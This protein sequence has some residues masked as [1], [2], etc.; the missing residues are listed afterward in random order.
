MT[1]STTIRVMISSRGS[2]DISYNGKAAK[3]SQVRL[4]VK[5]D[6]EALKLWAT[7]RQLFEC[8]INEDSSGAPMDQTWWEHCLR[9]AR[10]ADIVIVLYNGESG[11]GI[12][13]EPMGICHSELEAAMARQSAKVR[14]IL[15]PIAGLP[16]DP[17]QRKQDE[18]F[19]KYIESLDIFRAAPAKMGEEVIER[20]RQEVQHAL[21][22]MVQKCALTPDLAKSNTGPALIWHRMSFEERANAMRQEVAAILLD[23]GSS[24]HLDPKR[25]DI[26]SVLLN[27]KRLLVQLHAVPGAFSQPAARERVG[28]PFLLD[29]GLNSLLATCNGGPVH[30]VAGYKTFTESHALKMLGFPDAVVIPGVFG[31]HVADPVQKI[32]F[33]LLKN[34]ESPTSTRRSVIE[35]LEWL[36]RSGEAN[37]L[38]NNAAARK[39]IILAIA[40]EN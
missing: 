2:A 24:K 6:I 20:T 22:E 1:K 12:K 33:V 15:L 10:Q 34:C 31:L 19:R 3:L 16:N 5:K 39:R 9:Q 38:M 7:G 32:Q 36:Q 40:K 28:Q 37:S 35:W 13:K 27:G 17:V 14:G 26:I 25:A 11:S 18:A 21:V 30:L 23:R 29:P 8:W 4:A